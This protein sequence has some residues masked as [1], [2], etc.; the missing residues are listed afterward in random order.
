MPS[1][2]KQDPT[3]TTML[4]RAFVTQMNKRFGAVRKAT[5]QLVLIDDA[6]DLAKKSNRL[7]LNVT[8]AYKFQ[9]SPQKVTTFRKWLDQQINAGIL[10]VDKAGKPW[11]NTYVH[12]SYK[13]AMTEA[14]SQVHPE[15]IAGKV[16]GFYQGSRHQFLVSAFAA[17]ETVEKLE[18]LYTRAYGQLK[19]V[20]TQMS[21]QMSRIMADG[22]AHGKGVGEISRNLSNNI[23]KITKTRAR[24]IARTEIIH[25]HAEGML[26]GFT[27]LGI[28][29][30]AGV[31]EWTTAGDDRV[32]VECEGMDGE[33]FTIKQAH[34]LI[35]LHPNCRCAWIPAED[36]LEK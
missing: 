21:Q 2:L 11:T 29:K 35:P 25:A 30:V 6:F 32:C 20:T 4:R 24:V 28:K 36:I 9:T 34:G 8:K 17:P 18:L 5:R 26:D 14:Y 19:D 12:S 3:R 31:A 1:S 13:K 10:T 16:K 27:K 23:N 15:A 22:L 33:V 7:R